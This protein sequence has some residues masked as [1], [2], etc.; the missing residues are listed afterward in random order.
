[1]KNKINSQF[2]KG[3]SLLSEYNKSITYKCDCDCGDNE[4]SVWIDFEIEKDSDLIILTFYKDVK[5]YFWKNQDILWFEK[6]QKKIKKDGWKKENIRFFIEN[7][8]F[9]FLNQY[10]Y[11]FKK[12]LRL[13]FTGY[14]E[15]NE[16]FILREGEHFDNFIQMLNEGKEIMKEKI[17]NNKNGSMR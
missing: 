13:F 3:V 1:M 6:F 10:W 8:I 5:F 9:Y 12:S 7:T 16:D 15:M 2:K 17:T 11:R 14:L 4:H